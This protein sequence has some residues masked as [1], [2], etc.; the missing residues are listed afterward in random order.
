MFVSWFILRNLSVSLLIQQALCTFPC[1][2]DHNFLLILACKAVM[3]FLS[4][5]MC[6]FS[7]KVNFIFSKAHFASLKYYSPIIEALTWRLVH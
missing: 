7:Y 5:M 4:S 6:Y 3:N 2:L 1:A